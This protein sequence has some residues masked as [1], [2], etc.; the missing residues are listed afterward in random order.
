MNNNTHLIIELFTLLGNKYI[1]NY[2]RLRCLLGIVYRSGVLTTDHYDSNTDPFVLCSF[3]EK[4]TRQKICICYCK[5]ISI[6]FVYII[7]YF[8]FAIKTCYHCVNLEAFRLWF[9][10]V[11]GLCVV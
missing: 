5:M 11:F 6:V 4:E 1:Y 10:V 2:N 8:W 9:N 3:Q 7:N